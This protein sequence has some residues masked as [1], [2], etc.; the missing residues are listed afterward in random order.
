MRSPEF[1]PVYR[2][3]ECDGC[4]GGF[5][6][7]GF[8]DDEEGNWRYCERCANVIKRNRIKKIRAWEAKTG[9]H[10]SW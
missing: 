10:Y 1:A 3:G 5:P 4:H 8:E 9:E 7:Y 2:Y 6:L